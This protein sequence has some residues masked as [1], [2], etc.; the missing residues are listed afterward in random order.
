MLPIYKKEDWHRESAGQ[1]LYRGFARSLAVQ[2]AMVKCPANRPPRNMSPLD[3]REVDDWFEGKFGI[4]FRES[5]LFCSGD[6]EI[7]KAYAADY[8]EVR[9]MTPVSDYSFCWST[10]T[11]D[12][13]HEV[14]IF[15]GHKLSEL[16]ETLD[17]KCT[18]LGD[19][20]RSGYEIMLYGNS[21][22]IA[23]AL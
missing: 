7:A 15:T 17:Y 22:F 16:L 9:H 3:Q 18:D 2:E 8:G 20:I 21:G 4:R 1:L 14:S 23:H 13:Y 10:K 19:A 11:A 6:I 5:S 12:L